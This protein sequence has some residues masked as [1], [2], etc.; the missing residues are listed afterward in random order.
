[1]RQGPE[2]AACGAESGGNAQRATPRRNHSHSAR[3]DPPKA[4]LR[5]VWRCATHPPPD[6]P[7]RGLSPDAC[8]PR[9]S[10]WAIALC[11]VVVAACPLRGLWGFPLPPA[12][13]LPA[14]DAIVP[15]A[16]WRRSPWRCGR[17]GCRHR[18]VSFRAGAALRGA[19]AVWPRVAPCTDD[20][21]GPGSGRWP[22]PRLV[23]HLPGGGACA[24]RNT[25][26][27]G[28]GGPARCPPS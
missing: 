9:M 20:G 23:R 22:G 17:C 27:G 28:R 18:P 16:L 7:F 1:L 10:L 6:T 5:I 21:R 26:P 2:Q 12:S 15:V 13:F 14:A 4:A 11:A 25:I 24:V 3:R 19:C 8:G